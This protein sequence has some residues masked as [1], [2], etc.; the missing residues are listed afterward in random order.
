MAQR[1]EELERLARELADLAP[2]ERAKV[3]ART[4]HL[5]SGARLGGGF[6]IPSLGGGN[7]WVGGD[8]SREELYEDDGR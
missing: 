7:A 6:R 3:L 4:T 8:M 2:E 1:N 5:R